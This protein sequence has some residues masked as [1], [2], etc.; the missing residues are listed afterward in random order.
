[1]RPALIV[2][3]LGAAVALGCMTAASRANGDPML[4]IEVASTAV[5]VL[6]AAVGVRSMIRGWHL[7]RAL[8]SRSALGVAAGVQCRILPGGGRRAFVL[9][10]IRPQIYVGDE[11]FRAL[12][13]DEL[14]AVLFHEDHHRRTRAPLRATALEAWLTLAGRAGAVRRVL[15]DRLID[16]EE[17]ADAEALRRGV[18]PSALASA[19]LKA[20]PSFALG[21]SFAAASAQ[22]L[23]TLVAIA[24][25]AEPSDDARLP[26][27]WLPVA[28]AVVVVLACHIPGL[29]PFG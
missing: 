10:A 18:D 4:A 16:L 27:E 8:E 21:T 24:D 17:E 26:Y 13:E 6:W 1:M 12:E 14:Q 25:G 3:T 7:A 19:L 22:R 2:A 23:R 28:A 5:L 9:G 20:D 29:P 15:I 11:L